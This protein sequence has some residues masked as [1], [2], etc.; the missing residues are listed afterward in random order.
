M[1]LDH[2]E[3]LKAVLISNCELLVGK[4][5][6]GAQAYAMEMLVC[7]GPWADLLMAA[8]GTKTWFMNAA[9]DPAMDIATIAEYRE[10]YPWIDIEVVPNTGQMLL[11][12]HYEALL[13]R[14]AAAAIAAQT[15]QHKP[16]VFV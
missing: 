3:P 13:P 11:F 9:E 1:A 10:T 15:G 16:D 4:E 2:D 7:E 5:T 8:Q 6:D 14:V 12:Q